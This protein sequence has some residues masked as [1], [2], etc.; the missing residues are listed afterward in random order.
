M[1][2]LSWNF[3]INQIKSK[4]SRSSGLLAKLRY[5]VKTN[6]L[7]TVYF[8]IFDSILRYGIQVWGQNRNHTVKEIEQIQEKTIRIINFKRKGEQVN[9]LFKMT[10]IMKMKD[11]LTFNNCLFVYDQIAEGLPS[12]FNNFFTTAE[13]QHLY[14]TRGRS[15]NSIIKTISKSTTYGLNSVKHRAASDGTR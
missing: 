11:V 3:Q 1:S 10:K 12:S 15:N 7:R 14:N 5:Y 8:A 2:N 6:L 4:L 13:N 9:P